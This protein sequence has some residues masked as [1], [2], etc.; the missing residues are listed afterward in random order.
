[1]LQHPLHHRYQD[2]E[3]FQQTARIDLSYLALPALAFRLLPYGLS[4]TS[5]S[6][7][8]PLADC[9]LNRAGGTLNVIY[10]EPN[11]VGIAEI[12]LAQISVQMFFTAMLVDAL[13]AALEDRI[14]ALNGVGGDGGSFDNGLAIGAQLVSDLVPVA[15]VFFIGVVHRFMAG[16]IATNFHVVAGFVGHEIAFRA[17]VFP[18]DRR[19]VGNGGAVNV[20]ATG[21]AAAFN[22]GQYGILER[23]RAAA[24]LGLAF[25]T[26]DESFVGFHDLASAAQGANAGHAHCLADTV[27]H[28]PSG[29][30]GHAQGPGKLVAGDA[31]LAGA[32]QVHRLKPQVHGDVAVLENSANLD[33]ELLAALVA[34]P[35]ANPGRLATHLADPVNPAAVRANRAVRP[36]SGLN[37]SDSGGFG[38]HN[39]GG[40]DGLGH[41]AGF[42]DLNQGYASGLGLSSTITP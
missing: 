39:L 12:E 17:D 41:D 6:I 30:E 16:E 19:N 8:Q 40:K 37:P 25:Q 31:L 29:L 22:Q 10:A 7:G 2:R 4:V 28:E 15:N 5:R 11:A 20:E 21:R 18:Q 33:G 3:R 27:R 34:F 26:T 14:V 42:P 9:T 38:L 23:G 13:H 36:H 24:A 35:E 1:M 32:K